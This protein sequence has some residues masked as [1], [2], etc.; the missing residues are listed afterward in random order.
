MRPLQQGA[1]N[2]G[3]I[4]QPAG[5]APFIVVPAEYLHQIARGLCQTGIDHAGRGVDDDVTRHEG[6]GAVAQ[7][8]S[9]AVSG[10]LLE[11][12]VARESR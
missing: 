12:A 10:R 7:H 4:G 5:V 8:S 2:R 11:R 1:N 3:K 6:I 9:P